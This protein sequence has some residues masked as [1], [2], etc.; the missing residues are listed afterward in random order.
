MIMRWVIQA[1]VEDYVL[2]K[3]S[4]TKKGIPKSMEEVRSRRT[5]LSSG[6]WKQK[7]RSYCR[8]TAGGVVGDGAQGAGGRI[9]V[10]FADGCPNG[11]LSSCTQVIL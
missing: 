10:I 5:C 6:I 1:F 9:E 2:P 7:D 3:F 4:K 8:T 11:C